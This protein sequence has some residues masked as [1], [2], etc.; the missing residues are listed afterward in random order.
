ME[1]VNQLIRSRKSVR[2][3]YEHPLRE[4]DLKKLSAFI[5]KID[6]P[7]GIPVEFRLLDAREH[8][9]SS[10]VITGERLYVGAKL[11]RVPHMEE[12][13]GKRTKIQKIRFAKETSYVLK[14]NDL[15]KD[16]SCNTLIALLAAGKEN[17]CLVIPETVVPK[18]A[19]E[20]STVRPSVEMGLFTDEGESMEETLRKEEEQRQKAKEAALAEEKA[21]KEAAEAEKRRRAEC[22]ELIKEADTLKDE[23][24]F[25]EA[26]KRLA[27]ARGMGIADKESDIA[28]LE[29]EVKK[30]K[31]ENGFGKK[32]AGFLGKILEEE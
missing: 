10:P 18:P 5:K 31:E 30:L 6:N 24:K 28:A 3:Y 22:D 23:K 26:L 21:R 32:I 13:F 25:K 19:P 1:F 27:K 9:L 2:I 7:Y 29:Q 15:P 8:G 12:A 20:K 14:G 17:C 4:G 16:G 11:R